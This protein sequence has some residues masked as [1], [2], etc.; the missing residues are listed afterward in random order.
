MVIIVTRTEKSNR[1]GEVGT[2]TSSRGRSNTAP[3]L[4]WSGKI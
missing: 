2:S 1:L 4:A 3:L